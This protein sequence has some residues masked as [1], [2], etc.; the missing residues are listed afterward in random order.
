MMK[1]MLVLTVIAAACSAAMAQTAP[2]SSLR[3]YGIV[4][5]SV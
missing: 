2:A 5:G 3:L 1:R 4:D